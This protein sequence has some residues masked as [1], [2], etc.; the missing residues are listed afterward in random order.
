M[1]NLVFFLFLVG[2]SSQKTVL[3]LSKTAGY[4][5]ASIESGVQA[6]TT[7]AQEL[8]FKVITTEDTSLLCTEKY[9]AV[10]FLNTTGNILN[11]NERRCLR[12]FVEGGGGFVGIHSASDTEYA[13]P[14]Y[15]ETLVGA[16]FVSHPPVSESTV[17]VVDQTH[18]ST[19]HLQA[20]WIC[21]DEWYEF[22]RAPEQALVLMNVHGHPLAWCKEI[23][24]GRSFYTGRG[25]TKACF[26]ES[27]FLE[28][29]KGG[30]QWVSQ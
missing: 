10:V 8:E 27:A 19:S 3:V 12:S 2:C 6:V 22:D 14:W 29:I 24:K 25:H 26:A 21:T 7:I 1:R 9:D 16:W 13:W 30:L 4:R 28:H 11:E 15:G 5:H 18:P 17:Q 23:V 20:N